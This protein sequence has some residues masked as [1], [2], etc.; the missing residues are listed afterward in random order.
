MSK[1][2]KYTLSICVPWDLTFT[3]TKKTMNKYYSLDKELHAEVF[4]RKCTGVCNFFKMMDGY[5]C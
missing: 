3:L 1:L 2:S 4:R 5:I